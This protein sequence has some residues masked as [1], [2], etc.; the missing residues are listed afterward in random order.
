MAARQPKSPAQVSEAEVEREVLLA[1]A[2]VPG[3]TLLRNEVGFG[4]PHVIKHL[5]QAALKPWGPECVATALSVLQRNTITWGLGEGSPDLV[6]AAGPGR[7]G[8]GLELKRPVGG[9][10]SPAQQRF[11]SAMRA[12]G[13]FVAVVCSGAEA[14]AAVARWAA[15]ELE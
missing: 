3:L 5:L 15:G 11:H 13:L 12:R 4:H 6:G 1:T 9:V 8:G 14:E 10:V 7:R 2:K